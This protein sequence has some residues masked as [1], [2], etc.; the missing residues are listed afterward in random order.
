MKEAF[1]NLVGKILNVPKDKLAEVIYESDGVTLK[2]DAVDVLATM[3]A[4][5][6]KALKEANKTELTRMHDT[7]YSK[8]KGES[9][10]KYEQD[11]RELYKIDNKELKGAD[12]IKEIVSKNA[13]VEIDEEKLKLHPRYLELERKLT[14]DYMPKTE[15]EKI[16]AEFDGYKTEIEK[17][18]IGG[19]VKADAIKAFRALKPVLSKDPVRATNQ[20]TDFANKLLQFEYELQDDGNHIIKRDGK[21]LENANGHPVSFN[22]FVKEQASQFFDFEQQEDRSNSGNRNET[23][24]NIDVKL[25]ATEKEY[26]KALANESDPKKAVALMKAWELKNGN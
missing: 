6:I 3:D 21:R 1:E 20:E 9:L 11:L 13:N 16:K 8:G 15:Y 12:L 10:A 14:N 22:D 2:A 4:E 26:Q 5:R 25:P 23:I 19:A 18:K 24:F 17:S 7:G